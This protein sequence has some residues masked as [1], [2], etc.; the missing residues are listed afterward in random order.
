MANHLVVTTGVPGSATIVQTDGGAGASETQSNALFL[1]STAGPPPDGDADGDMITVTVS[2]IAGTAASVVFAA[3]ATLT[4]DVTLSDVGTAEEV[5]SVDGTR[6]FEFTA[7]IAPDQTYVSDDWDSIWARGNRIENGLVVAA[8]SYGFDVEFSPPSE[9]F[10]GAHAFPLG[11]GWT[12]GGNTP[13]GAGVWWTFDIGV[14][15]TGIRFRGTEL[16]VT[17]EFWNLVAGVDPGFIFPVSYAAD[18]LEFSMGQGSSLDGYGTRSSEI[19]FSPRFPLPWPHYELLYA[20]ANPTRPADRVANEIEFK[21]RHSSL[22]G[23]DRR[24][25]VAAASKTVT[26]TMSSDWGYRTGGTYGDPADIL[27][28]GVHFLEG[29]PDGY[30][31]IERKVQLGKASNPN[32]AQDVVGSYLQ[33]VFPRGVIPYYLLFEM[34]QGKENYDSGGEPTLAGKWHWEFSNTGGASWIALTESWFF[35]EAAYMVAPSETY[36]D[37]IAGPSAGSTHWRMVLDEGPAFG[38]GTIIR[39]IL[40]TFRDYAELGTPLSVSFTDDT[41][42]TPATVTITSESPYIVRLSDGTDDGLTF[43]ATIIPNLS[44]TI[45]F[46]DAADDGITAYGSFYPSVFGQTMVI[47]TGRVT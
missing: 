36:F 39:Q 12:P 1:A 38:G 26:F 44:L 9:M 25:G 35:R 22:D 31:G 21:V 20:H 45:A 27:F 10:D 15:I 41:D 29:A 32:T 7:N 8:G 13:A 33:F 2:V 47:T 40:F 4:V 28:D 34:A 37:V 6:I 30:G 46:S 23:G 42:A 18:F 3:G 19:S 24:P 17:S 14:P 16:I 11:N 5:K 43:T